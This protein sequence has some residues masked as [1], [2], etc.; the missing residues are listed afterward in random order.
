[1]IYA[2]GRVI[3]TVWYRL[4]FRWRVIG[5]ENIPDGPMI[6]CSNHISNWDPITVGL[7]VRRRKV[8]FM[9]KE[10]LFRVPVVAFLVRALQ[11][12]PVKRGAADKASLKYAVE[13]LRSGKIVAM[14]PEGT[15]SK[16]GIP[17]KGHPGVAMIAHRAK[18]PV[19]P[20][21]I[22]GNYKLFSP[23]VVR[24]GKPMDLQTDYE[25]KSSSALFHAISERIMGQIRSLWETGP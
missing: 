9:A 6:L 13:L 23:L 2:L 16:T 12:F 10:E 22:I 11:A 20:M 17:G 7:C 1:M 8:H 21:A 15:R 5:R 14:F 24:I 4:F 18:V 19:V 3:M 25:Q